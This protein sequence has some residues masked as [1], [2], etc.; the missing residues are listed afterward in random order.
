MKLSSG[1]IKICL[2]NFLRFSLNSGS[3]IIGIDEPGNTPWSK[4]DKR[5]ISFAINFG[6]IV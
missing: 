3:W 2:H 6:T 5:G 1:S 4:F